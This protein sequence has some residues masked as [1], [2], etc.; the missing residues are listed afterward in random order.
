MAK[1]IRIEVD[2]TDD[3]PRPPKPQPKPRLPTI[4]M[5]FMPYL[6]VA[7]PQ[8]RKPP[9]LAGTTVDDVRLAR[10][11]EGLCERQGQEQVAVRLGYNVR[12][13]RRWIKSKKFSNDARTAVTELLKKPDI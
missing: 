9:K 5:P 6:P 8:S 13:I 4:Y 11:L 10:A 7:R 1:N 3:R 12:S 2:A